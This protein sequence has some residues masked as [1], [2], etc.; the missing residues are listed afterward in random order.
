ML[1]TAEQTGVGTCSDSQSVGCLTV[2]EVKDDHSM[3]FGLSLFLLII[4]KPRSLSHL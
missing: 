1:L 4:N 2:G 3:N